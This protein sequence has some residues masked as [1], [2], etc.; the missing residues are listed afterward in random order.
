GNRPARLRLP[1]AVAASAHRGRCA[2]REPVRGAR[3]ERR[4]DRTPRRARRRRGLRFV[5]LPPGGS[6]ASAPA[7]L[8]RPAGAAIPACALSGSLVAELRDLETLCVE[9][10]ASLCASRAPSTPTCPPRRPSPAR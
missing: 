6:P 3:R 5:A 2:D 10:R 8:E 1:L 9:G 7:R 4:G